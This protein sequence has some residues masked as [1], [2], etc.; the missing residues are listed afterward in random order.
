MRM[1]NNGMEILLRVAHEQALESGLGM[2]P[3]DQSWVLS[4]MKNALLVMPELDPLRHEESSFRPGIG[5]PSQACYFLY[6]F[7]ELM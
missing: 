4:G 1:Q 3:S 6:F 2:V 7:L 5:P